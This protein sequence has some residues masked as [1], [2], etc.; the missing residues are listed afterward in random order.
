MSALNNSITSTL[1][2]LNIL[3]DSSRQYVNRMNSN[4]EV[5][6][7]LKFIGK[8]N[9]SEKI[10]TRHM[11]VQPS[12][13]GTSISRT[14]IYQDNRGNALN[15][16]QDTI[17]RSFE[18]LITYDR[19]KDPSHAFLKKNLILDLQKATKGL[20]NLKHTYLDDTKFCCDIDT[21]L[22]DIT[23]KLQPYMQKL[24]IEEKKLENEINL[25]SISSVNSVNS[26]VPPVS[27]VSAVPPIPPIPE[28]EKKVETIPSPP[29]SHNNSSTKSFKKKYKK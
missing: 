17:N 26:E 23:A 16:C 21:I 9:K 15:F 4:Q 25:N 19:S 6:S 11:Y 14:F 27:A 10:N 18:L 24:N 29:E 2:L 3:K 5:I 7:K 20:V 13:I 1:S 8:L 22:Q 12:G 28:S